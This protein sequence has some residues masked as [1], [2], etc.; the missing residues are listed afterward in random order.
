VSYHKGHVWRSAGP[1][2]GGNADL[3]ACSSELE[4]SFGHRASVDSCRPRKTRVH[5]NWV[6]G[7]VRSAE[8]VRF[9]QHLRRHIRGRVVLLW[10]GLHAHRSRET[11]VYLEANTRWLTVHRLPAY[12]PEL[13]STSR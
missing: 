3:E 8:V 1:R 7:T 5:L 6:A 12:A 9:L 13:G 2:G 4:E 11:R 10:G